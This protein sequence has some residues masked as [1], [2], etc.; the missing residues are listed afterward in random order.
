VRTKEAARAFLDK[1]GFFAKDERV[2]VELLSHPLLSLA[3]RTTAHSTTGKVLQEGA[4]AIAIVM[5]DETM[6]SAG[7]AVAKH[8]GE[9]M[10]VAMEEV[11]EVAEMA[12]NLVEAA[13]VTVQ[14]V[15]KRVT[16]GREIQGEKGGEGGM[17]ANGVTYAA[18]LRGN[19]LFSH[20]NTLA[21]ARSRERQLLIDRDPRTEQNMLDGLTEQ[22][23]VAKANEAVD[24]IE[25]TNG[26]EDGGCIGAKRLANG[27]IVLELRTAEGARWM[28]QHKRQFME[29]FSGTTIMKDR[30]V[31][32]I[33][34]YVPL[35]HSPEAFAEMR[36]IKRESRLPID[37]LVSTRWIKPIHRRTE[38]QRSAHVIAKL[39]TTEAANQSIRD[40]VIIAGK[41][42]WAR[43]MKRELRRCLKCQRYNTRHM[44]ADCGGLETCGTCGKGHRTAECEETDTSKFHCTSCDQNGHASWDRTCPAF[45]AACQAIA[46]ADPEHTYKFFPSDSPWT[47]VQHGAS[48]N[49]IDAG[50]ATR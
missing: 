42:V 14:E 34:E 49:T 44:A 38:G 8:V 40:G 16:E 43:R 41:R 27:G 15:A 39:A 29:K 1:N 17:G 28:Q 35:T 22:E 13:Q 50:E 36:K 6:R 23:L 45:L 19:V 3:H 48:A 12:K 32:V 31:S 4:R 30:T 9:R 25:Q 47:W 37:T 33:I 21:R 10:E 46:R 18:V 24:Q 20:P 2:T 5:V 11:K 26:L 7:E